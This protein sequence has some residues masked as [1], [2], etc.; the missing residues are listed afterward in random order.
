MAILHGVRRVADARALVARLGTKTTL[1]GRS[2]GH[3]E[4]LVLDDG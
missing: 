1:F 4:G 2:T 3:T